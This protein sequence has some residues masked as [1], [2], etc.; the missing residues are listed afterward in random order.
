MCAVNH[1]FDVAAERLVTAGADMNCLTES[2]VRNHTY[3]INFMTLHPGCNLIHLAVI[4][5]NTYIIEFLVL[6]GA[7]I[8]HRNEGGYTPL[9]L[10]CGYGR[11]EM[12][13][14]MVAMFGHDSQSTDYSKPF[15]DQCTATKGNSK[16][17]IDFRIGDLNGVSVI[18]NALKLCDTKTV[19]VLRK[20]FNMEQ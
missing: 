20:H 1:G 5:K 7:N 16:S 3:K 11:N 4:K 13:Q 19:S 17:E 8:N 18:A 6:H 12:V 2:I 9:H 15:I 14:F 10:S